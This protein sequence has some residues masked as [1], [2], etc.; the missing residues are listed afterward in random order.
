MRLGE[1]NEEA[2][3]LLFIAGDELARAREIVRI[4][5][6]V[7]AILIEARD[8]LEDPKHTFSTL[9]ARGLNRETMFHYLAAFATRSACGRAIAKFVVVGVAAL[10]SAIVALSRRLTRRA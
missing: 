1:R 3:G 9:T 7:H 10:G 4:G 5:G 8:I 6:I 2:E